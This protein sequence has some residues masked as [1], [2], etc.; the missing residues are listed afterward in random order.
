LYE[1]HVFRGEATVSPGNSLGYEPGSRHAAI[2][3]SRQPRGS[4]HDFALA[5]RLAEESGLLNVVLHR[6]GTLRVESINSMSPHFAQ[7]YERA[8]SEGVGIIVYSEAIDTGE[9]DSVVTS[10]A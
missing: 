7:M 4:E 8:L 2:V 9:Q 1:V 10:D 5:A 3:L 6:G